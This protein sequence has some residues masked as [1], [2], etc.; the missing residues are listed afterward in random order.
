MQCYRC[1]TDVMPRSS[2]LNSTGLVLFI[3]FL[4]F[5]LP[6]CWIPFVVDSCK[7]KVC[8]QCGCEMN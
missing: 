5:C 2:G 7:K 4:L 6:L 8:P 3:I 1:N